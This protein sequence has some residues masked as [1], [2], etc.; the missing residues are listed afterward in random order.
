MIRLLE[1]VCLT[2][3]I[4]AA[5]DCSGM[6]VSVSQ[7]GGAVAGITAPEAFLGHPVGADYKLAR[8]PP[9]SSPSLRPFPSEARHWDGAA[10]SQSGRSFE[11]TRMMSTARR[12]QPP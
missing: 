7:T 1:S 11:S 4:L 5:S 3:C 12:P 6:Q 8:C 2:A 9:A 10:R